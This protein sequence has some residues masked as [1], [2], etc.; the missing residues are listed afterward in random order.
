MLEIIGMTLEDAKIIE[1]CGADRIELVSAL[2]EGGLT[3]S[4]GMIESVIKNVKIPVNVMIRNHAKGFIYSDDEIDI[5]I[6][7]ID[8]VRNLGANGVVLGVLDKNKNI[9]ELQLRK[10]S[11]SCKGIDVTF[12]K[13][14][15]E[16]NIIGSVKTLS[17]YKEIK[18][19]LTSGG[20]GDIVKN[21]S[22][23]KEMIKNSKHINILLGGGL[24]FNNIEMLKENTEFTDFHFGTAVRIDN[25]PFE[26]ISEE[27]L[28]YLVKLLKK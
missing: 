4:F 19:I 28:K 8:I 5:M 13:A 1:Y 15:D 10:I 20:I 11:E 16:T 18:N 2:T 12:H 6:R 27:K 23:I 3:P 25:K 7:D 22:V 26:E 17:K 14:I 24:N 9:S 21:I